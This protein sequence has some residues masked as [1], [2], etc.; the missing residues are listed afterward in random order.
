MDEHFYLLQQHLKD[1][2][3]I[4]YF[5]MFTCHETALQKYKEYVKTQ[6]PY[7]DMDVYD[8]AHKL[9]GTIFNLDCFLIDPPNYVVLQDGDYLAL[10]QIKVGSVVRSR[11]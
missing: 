11:E 8:E 5:E 2:D 7:L 3:G 6:S 9:N 1:T 4:D 10:M